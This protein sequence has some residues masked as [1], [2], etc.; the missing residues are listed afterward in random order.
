MSFARPYGLLRERRTRLPAPENARPAP[1]IVV[2]GRIDRD[3]LPALCDRVRAMLEGSAADHLVC[4][5]GDL[6]RP[7]AVVVDALARLQLTARRLGRRVSLRNACGDLRSL[8]AFTGLTDAVP[9]CSASTVQA[10]REP[11][12]GKQVRGVEEEADSRDPPAR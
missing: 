5:V 4:D 1:V 3:D 6:D 10:E 2:G 11:E 7:D 12:Q 8:L 9:L